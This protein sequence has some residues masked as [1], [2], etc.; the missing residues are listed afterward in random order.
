[1]QISWAARTDPGLRRR[2][3]EDS[4]CANPEFGFFVVADGMG[5]HAG[6]EIASEL[7]VTEIQTVIESTTTLGAHDTWPVPFAALMPWII[8]RSCPVQIC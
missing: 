3:N 7:A 8:L 5:G 2:Q 4:F 1:M 6:G